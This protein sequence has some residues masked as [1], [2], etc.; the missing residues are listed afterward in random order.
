MIPVIVGGLTLFAAYKVG[1]TLLR[2][3]VMT[4]ERRAIFDAAMNR[5]PG[6]EPDKMLAL[7]AEYDK[8]GLPSYADELRKRAALRSLPADVHKA[9]KAAIQKALSSTDPIGIRLMANACQNMGMY[10]TAE[11]LRETAEALDEQAF[12]AAVAP[13][14]PPPAPAASVTPAATTAVPVAGSPTGTATDTDPSTAPI[15]TVDSSGIQANSPD[16]SIPSTVSSDQM[17]PEGWRGDSALPQPA[18]AGF[19]GPSSV[20]IG[21]VAANKAAAAAAA[22]P[23]P[24][25]VVNTGD[26]TSLRLTGMDASLPSTPQQVIQAAA[27]AGLS[28]DDYLVAAGLVQ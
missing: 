25:P 6:L 14:M 9:R 13:D 4:E 21:S 8:A 1:T 18:M 28:V 15:A 2:K 16:Q 12:M 27:A 17:G 10:T 7:A 26:P 24:A 19:A 23:A 3:G 22:T 5:K 20:I 11:K